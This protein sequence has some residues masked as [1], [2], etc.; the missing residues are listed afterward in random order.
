LRRVNNF[1]LKNV[2]IIPRKAEKILA[3]MEMFLAPITRE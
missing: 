3:G 1:G 2:R